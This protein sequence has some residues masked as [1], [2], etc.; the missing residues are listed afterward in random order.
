MADLQHLQIQKSILREK[1]RAALKRVSVV[2]L[3]KKS[4]KIF[5]RVLKN[6]YYKRAKCV[7]LYASLP[8][9]VSTARIIR[10]SLKLGKT[11]CLP[12]ADSKSGNMSAWR[13]TKVSDLRRG[14]FGILEPGR[15]KALKRHPSA[16]DLIL[17]PGLG[18]DR[19]GR[20]LGRGKGYYDRF[21]IKAKRARRIGLAFKEQLVAKIPAT[22]H[23]VRMHQVITD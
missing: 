1:L 18:F 19:K 14:V 20:R 17:V 5:S 12:A 10:E 7:L 3:K 6:K 9:E 23:D 4:N 13:I 15:K 16:I 22:K 2:K 8:K 21:L 11:V